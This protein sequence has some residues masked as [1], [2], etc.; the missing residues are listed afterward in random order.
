MTISFD[1]NAPV[2][3]AA[4]LTFLS[5][6]F[7]CVMTILAARLVLKGRRSGMVIFHW[8]IYIGFFLFVL[9]MLFVFF[10]DNSYYLLKIINI[11]AFICNRNLMNS[12]P[13]SEFVKSIFK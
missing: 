8:M 7:Y 4:P 10:T 13:F 3:L 9:S 1:I 2:S 5:V 11:F 6:M 12:R